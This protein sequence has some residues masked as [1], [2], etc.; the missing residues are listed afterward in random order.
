MSRTVFGDSPYD[1]LG[2]DVG[3]S[4]AD[5]HAAYRRAMRSAQGDRD[6][7]DRISRANKALRRSAGRH[8][9]DLLTPLPVR[10]PPDEGGATL[11]AEAR[12]RMAEVSPL[13]P[14]PASLGVRPD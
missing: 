3:A 13:S 8:E 7:R 10:L 2:L 9:A 12:Q 5:I 1:V 4:D 11:L 6:L 14:D